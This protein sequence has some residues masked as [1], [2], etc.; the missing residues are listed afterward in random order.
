MILEGRVDVWSFIDYNNQ[1]EDE[2]VN[3]ELRAEKENKIQEF[4][5]TSTKKCTLVFELVDLFLEIF[6]PNERN[7]PVS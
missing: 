3:A 6:D 5:K 1:V 7:I 4:K 2:K